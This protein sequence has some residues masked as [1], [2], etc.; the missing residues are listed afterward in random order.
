MKI[1]ILVFMSVFLLL[2]TQVNALT[3][4]Y[5]ED[6]LAY[7]QGWSSSNTYEIHVHGNEPFSAYF[8]EFETGY[9]A[10]TTFY[11]FD[12]TMRLVSWDDDS[13]DSFTSKI[14]EPSLQQGI[15]YL[16]VSDYNFWPLDAEGVM[17]QLP[18]YVASDWEFEYFYSQHP[19]SELNGPLVGWAF[20]GHGICDVTSYTLALEGANQVPE[21]ATMLLF[22]TGL[23]GLIGARLRKK[24]K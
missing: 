4:N 13:G 16:T 5:I 10:D 15:Y 22:G 7:G 8:S 14:Y 21:P 18:S 9:V 3:V 6:D 11:L 20:L 24:K 2:A 23:V 19:V 17:F 12:S 1:Y